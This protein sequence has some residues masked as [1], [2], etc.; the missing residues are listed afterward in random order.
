MEHASIGG[1]VSKLSI[2]HSTV[3]PFLVWGHRRTLFH[4]KVSSAGITCVHGVP[5][6][7]PSPQGI[8]GVDSAPGPSAR[9]IH[10]TIEVIL[11]IIYIFDILYVISFVSSNP[12]GRVCRAS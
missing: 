10:H 8:A 5:G 6:P 1:P 2:L 3:F 4:I 11:H 12:E 9:G 7:T